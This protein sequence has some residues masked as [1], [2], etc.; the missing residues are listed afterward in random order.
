MNVL[1]ILSSI[2][3]IRRELMWL[4]I[5]ASWRREGSLY[6]T[7]TVTATQRS[8]K[9]MK[10]SCFS[11]G[12]ARLLKPTDLEKCF[13]TNGRTGKTRKPGSPLQIPPREENCR[14]KRSGMLVEKFKLNSRMR[15]IWTRLQLYL[16]PRRP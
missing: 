15:P 11:P 6:N 7:A 5:T 12:L 2:H 16:N 10:Y 8:L 9:S 1:R 13:S 14:V 3:R 4:R